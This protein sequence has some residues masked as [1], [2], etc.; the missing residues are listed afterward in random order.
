MVKKRKERAK[1]TKKKRGGKRGMIEYILLVNK[2]GQ[3][4]V[5]KYFDTHRP[6]KERVLFE[7]EIV[8]KCLLRADDQCGFVEHQGRKVVYRR[9]A[10]LFFIVG[11][12]HSENELAVYEF[13]HNLVELFDRYFRQVVRSLPLRVMR[14]R[15]QRQMFTA[16]CV[17]CVVCRCVRCVRCVCVCVGV[18]K[19]AHSFTTVRT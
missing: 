11:I 18:Y 2:Q 7:T 5:S 4:R 12:D 6:P 19:H 16:C 10:S 17:V 9:Y 15:C 14:L 13:I 3:A 1:R 8:R